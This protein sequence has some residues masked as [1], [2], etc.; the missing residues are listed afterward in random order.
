[1]KNSYQKRTKNDPRPIQNEL[2]NNGEMDDTIYW[3]VFNYEN[4]R[5]LTIKPKYKTDHPQCPTL[6]TFFNKQVNL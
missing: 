4:K 1:M 3:C 6:F 5:S 2:K